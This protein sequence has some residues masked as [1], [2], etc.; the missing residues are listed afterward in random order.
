MLPK[1]VSL[2]QSIGMHVYIYYHQRDVLPSYVWIKVPV[3]TFVI[4]F[5]FFVS[6]G[7]LEFVCAQDP[8]R[9]QGLLIGLL[10]SALLFG[11]IVGGGIFTA[12]K[13]GYQAQ[14]VGTSSTSCGVWLYVFCTAATILGIVVW[15]AV[16]KWYKNRERDEPETYRIFIENYYDH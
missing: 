13:T 15:V 3:L 10:F 5:V 11:V 2:P 14:D 16:A 7:M 9:L 1:V 12:W 4:S 8:Y 6:K